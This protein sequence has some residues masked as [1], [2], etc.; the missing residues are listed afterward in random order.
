MKKK[1]KKVVRLMCSMLLIAGMIGCGS[2]NGGASKDTGTETSTSTDS[3]STES[4]AVSGEISVVSREDGSGTR[5]A[6]VELTGVQEKDADGNKIDNTTEDAMIANSTE[7]VMT[8]VE[9]NANAIGYISLGSMGDSVKGIQVD[10]VD[11][12]AENI[13]NGSY[14]LSRPFNIV[15]KGTPNDAAQDFINFIM[16]EEGQKVIADNKYIEVENK[17]S[18][19][20]SGA[21]GKIVVAGSSSV[22]PVME[23]LQEAYQAVNGDVEIEIQESDSTTGVNATADGT[24]DIGMASRELSDEESGK[25]LSATA[26]AMDGIVVIVNKDNNITGLTK[27]QIKDVFCGNV[28][29]WSELQ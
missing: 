15:T 24:C 17:G 22:T 18:F 19:T 23:K 5:S 14:T 26:I 10:S 2:S 3:G 21:S 28:T 8:T 11:P 20:S 27:D 1:A 9:G 25:G 6:F 16:S 29:D 7:I 13:V 4:Q 12:T